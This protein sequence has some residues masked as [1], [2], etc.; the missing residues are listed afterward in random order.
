MQTYS[1][2]ITDLK[3]KEVFV[4]GANKQGFHGAGAAGYA[5][6]GTYKD[7]RE[8]DYNYV[9]YGTPHRW[10]VKGKLYL[11]K[12][13]EGWS[14]AL[15]TATR[16]GAKRSL[17]PNFKP[18]YE[19]CDTRPDWKFY[20]AYQDGGGNLN[21]WTTFELVQFMKSAGPIPENLVIHESLLKYF[22]P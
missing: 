17:R 5:S 16:P 2:N 3:D 9:A 20:L 12:G 7:W 6:F 11:Q 10:N 21:G 13:L 1:G 22:T 8:C 15:P 18:L 4:F 14:Y 19:C